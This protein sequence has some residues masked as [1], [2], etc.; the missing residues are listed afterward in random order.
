MNKPSSSHRNFCVRVAAARRAD[1]RQRNPPRR[2][3][4]NGWVTP[5][6]THPPGVARK[7]KDSQSFQA[8]LPG[9]ALREKRN[10]FAHD[11]NQSYNSAYPG[12]QEGRI[13]IVTNVGPGCGGRESAGARCG[14]QGGL[15]V[16]DRRASDER[17]CC[18]RQNR[19][20]L[21]PVAGVKSAE[22][23]KAQPGDASR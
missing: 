17:R 23:C 3:R 4:Q 18:V 21:A 8:D 15:P 16:S 22:V 11:P 13:A 12:P 9:P 5:S 20:V 7:Q 6:L 1:Q 10:R 2:L 14:S 19:V